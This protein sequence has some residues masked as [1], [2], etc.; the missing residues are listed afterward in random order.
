MG[1]KLNELL[2]RKD[3]EKPRVTAYVSP[4][5]YES[6]KIFCKSHEI[7]MSQCVEALIGDVLAAQ[8]TKVVPISRAPGQPSAAGGGGTRNDD[9]E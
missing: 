7:T 2:S 1:N 8:R 9:E 6:F 5:M 4:E 3:K